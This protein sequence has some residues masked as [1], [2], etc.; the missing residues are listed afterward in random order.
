MKRPIT[1]KAQLKLNFLHVL[2]DCFIESLDLDDA[3][4]FRS[5]L[6]ILGQFSCDPR[7]LK[8]Q[9]MTLKKPRFCSESFYNCLA[10]FLT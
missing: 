9:H 8:K 1:Y 7:A 6:I 3:G 10:T 5:T 4:N 2:V